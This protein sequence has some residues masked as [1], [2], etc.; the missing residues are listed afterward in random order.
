MH[1]VSLQGEEQK[2]TQNKRQGAL[3]CLSLRQYSFHILPERAGHSPSLQ[4]G[5]DGYD[6]TVNANLYIRLCMVSPVNI[7]A[8]VIQTRIYQDS[9]FP[10]IQ[11]PDGL[12]GVPVSITNPDP[13][14]MPIGIYRKYLFA[15]IG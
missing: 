3:P 4:G 14:S 15:F 1:S 2:K 12:H 9:T 7:S 8:G 6:S 5:D 10:A 11:L 13:L